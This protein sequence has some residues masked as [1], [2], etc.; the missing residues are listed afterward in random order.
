MKVHGDWWWWD[1]NVYWCLIPTI[2]MSPKRA[3]WDWDMI[4]TFHFL[5]CYGHLYFKRKEDEPE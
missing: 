4:L 3:T 1:R 2:C 5:K